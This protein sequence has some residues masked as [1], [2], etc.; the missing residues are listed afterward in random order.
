MTSSNPWNTAPSHSGHISI[1]GASLFLSV[2]GP[3]RDDSSPIVLVEAGIADCSN[4]WPAVARFVSRFAR[5]YTYDRPGWGRSDS[6][7]SAVDADVRTAS[8]IAKEYVAL[9][10]AAGVLTGPYILVGHS[11]GGILVREFLALRP[12]NSSCVGIVFVDAVMEDDLQIAWPYP[13]L[14]AMLGSGSAALDL[15][16]TTGLVDKTQ[17]TPDEWEAFL[18]GENQD[19]HGES[20][21]AEFGGLRQSGEDLVAKK[22]LEYCVMGDRSVSVIRAHRENEWRRIYEAGLEAGNGTEEDRRTLGGFLEGME[23]IIRVNQRKLLKIS[24]NS[25]EVDLVDCG[26]Q[27]NQERP[28]VVAD[29]IKWILESYA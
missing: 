12:L 24:R 8:V 28:D 13:A 14:R 7:N 9:L 17:L 11:Y 21:A 2:A 6:I 26:H 1:N 18:Q 19:R 20:S 15:F 3:P 10:Q 27:V 25:R 29:E 23:D 5:I 4:A 22:Q 16:K